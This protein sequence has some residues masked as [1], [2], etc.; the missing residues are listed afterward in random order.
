M[1]AVLIA[2]VDK[3]P[4]EIASEFLGLLTVDKQRAVC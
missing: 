2:T 4:D 3:T 1:F